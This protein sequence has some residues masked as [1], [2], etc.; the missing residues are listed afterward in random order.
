ME[1][2][3]NKRANAYYEGNLPSPDLKPTETDPVPVVT[4]YIKGVTNVP[5]HCYCYRSS[6]IYDLFIDKYVHKKYISDSIPP[7]VRESKDTSQRVTVGSKQ[8]DP[9]A[10]P[11]PP[12]SRHIFPKH[13]QET[14]VDDTSIQSIDES[15]QIPPRKDINPIRKNI[16]FD[17]SRDH[18]F[19]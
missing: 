12:P 8:D 7:Q 13:N 15:S 16:H 19:V 9:S 17:V 18:N 11:P 3:G 14:Y 4:K 1:E 5:R 6:N 2:W 10:P